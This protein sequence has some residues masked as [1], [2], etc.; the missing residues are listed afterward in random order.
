MG[1]ERRCQSAINTPNDDQ[2]K[3]IKGKLEEDEDKFEYQLDVLYQWL[4]SYNEF[5]KNYDRNKVMNFLR[6]CKYDMEKCKKKLEAH[7]YVRHEFPHIFS[8]LDPRSKEIADLPLNGNAFFLPNLS[9]N[10]ERIFVLGLHNTDLDKMD[11]MAFVKY[12]Y[13]CYDLALSQPYPVTGDIMICDGKGFNMKHFL[14][15]I[16]TAVK[17][18]IEIAYKGY[19]M[20]MKAIYIVN[21]PSTVDKMV[22]TWKLFLTEKIRQR[23]VVSKTCDIL[24][25]VFPPNCLPEEYGGT[26]PKINLLMRKWYNVLV[27]NEKWFQDQESCKS[28][29]RPITGKVEYDDRFGVEGTFR[30]LTID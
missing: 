1:F 23:V 17:D 29:E 11:V 19:L 2:I 6:A 15:C 12:S 22:A 16:N 4:D 9:P 5:P 3:F 18:S 25:R 7:F 21:A 24:Q 27:E 14:K 20:R 13:M 26:L 10:G 30:V 8:N 28:T